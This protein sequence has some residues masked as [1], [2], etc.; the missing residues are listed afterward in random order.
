MRKFFGCKVVQA[1][2][3]ASTSSAARRQ[4]RSNLTR[5]QPSW[6]SA[7]Q[8]EGL[9]IRTLSEEEKLDKVGGEG[10]KWWT[11]EYSQ[12]YKSMT[13]LFIQAVM[14]GHPDALWEV[15]RKLP[16]HAD[17]LLQ[18]AEVYRH[19]EEYAQAVDFVD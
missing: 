1:N 15:Q 16:W 3:S 6:W 17:N 19:R 14:S 13:K 5:P 4:L 8:R 2:K 11:V 10:D 12:R 9:S 18:L 7:S